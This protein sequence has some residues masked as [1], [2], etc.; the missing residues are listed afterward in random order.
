M[1]LPLAP[2][3]SAGSSLIG[4]VI[5]NIFGN[6]SA[7][8]AQKREDTAIQRRVADA[9]AAGVHPLFALG[10][11]VSSSAPVHVGSMGSTFRDMGQDISRAVSA[12]RSPKVVEDAFSKAMQGAQLERASLENT[13]L[14][15]QI[16]TAGSPPPPPT[17]D[18]Q[19]VIPGQG[20]SRVVV[21]PGPMRVFSPKYE[22]PA[23]D[24][25][26]E[27]GE[28]SDF[29]GGARFV[30]DV[31]RAAGRDGIPGLSVERAREFNWL[32]RISYGKKK[33]YDR[34]PSSP[35]FSELR[36]RAFSRFRR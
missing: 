8:K 23:Q 27:Y 36:A 35:S 13:L 14:R 29:V 34:V 18:V 31:V 30:R 3:I 26:N 28:I 25:E 33:Y 1:A 15:K 19:P 17:G 6:K 12:N 2:I 21:V 20:D 22:T 11:N 32:P 7:K 9:N 5:D 24:M 10:A 16:L 4:G